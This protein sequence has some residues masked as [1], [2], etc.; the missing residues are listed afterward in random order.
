MRAFEEINSVASISEAIY[1]KKDS[2]NK[3]F[4]PLKFFNS[5]LPDQKSADMISDSVKQLSFYKNA[6]YNPETDVYLIVLTIKRDVL[7]TP[8]REELIQ[9]IIGKVD[10]FSNKHNVKTYYSGLPY[11]RTATSLLLRKEVLLFIIFAGLVCALILYLFFRSFRVMLFSMIIVGV[12]VIFVMGCMG[13]LGYQITLLT[14]LVPTLIIVI[15]VPN[16]V[17]LLYRY[18][19]EYRNLGNKNL[20]LQRVIRKIGVA[21]FLTNLT[22][23]CGF[24]TFIL[25]SSQILREFGLTASLGILGVFFFSII[26]IPIIFSFAQAPT[27]KHL[28]HLDNKIMNR[29]IDKIIHIVQYHRRVV[30]IISGLFLVAGVY[31]ITLMKSTGY[32]VD[33]LPHDNKI[34]VDLKFLEKNFNGALPLEITIDTKKPKGALKLSTL[35]KV[36]QFYD[37]LATID[38]I[39]RP[40]SLLDVVK[41]ARQSYY[42]G[43]EKYYS[44]PNEFDKNFIFSYITKETSKIQYSLIDSTHQKI[45]ISCNVKDIG[46]VNMALLEKRV[47][48]DIYGIFDK[49]QYDIVVTGSSI[50]FFRGTNYLKE[51]LMQS[52]LLAVLLISVIMII[53]FRSWKMVIVSLIPNLLPQIL[54]AS[55]MGYLGVPIKPSTI[56]VFS[57][58]FGISVDD[59]IHFLSKYRQELPHL[60]W[61]IKLTV[62]KSLKETGTSMIYTSIILFSGFGIFI[63]S[64]F[65][66][67]IALGALVSTTLLI[68]MVSNIILLPSLLLTLD[69]II[70]RKELEDPY[71]HVYDDD[72]EIELEEKILE[73]KNSKH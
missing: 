67:T 2:E 47:L 43:N 30:Y 8:E 44:I 24:A 21:S 63:F 28:K 41:F 11:I 7:N 1:L 70:T 34:M 23:A 65:G 42:N 35:N 49:S 68:A 36:Q 5:D 59:T 13:I 62:L 20:A 25:T 9:R 39:S 33:D 29:I 66:G 52:I 26:L 16:C 72:E 10:D 53:M 37:S 45:R 6:L 54:A 46:T 31:G 15:C 12:S 27:E 50:I 71:L 60:D 69:K 19:M 40:L 14:S 73:E 17:F 18:Q 58:A 56:L 57:I 51:N 4:T 22:T 64:S 32:V 3:K 38:E 48:E 55:L 61:N